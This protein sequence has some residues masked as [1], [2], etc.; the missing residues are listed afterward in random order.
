MQYAVACDTSSTL[1][2]AYPNGGIPHAYIVGKDGMICW[3]GHPMSGMKEALFKALQ[4]P[5]EA[6]APAP[7]NTKAKAAVNDMKAPAK[8]KEAI[9]VD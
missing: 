3:S 4:A 7:V 1:S 5:E 6:S 2:A 9:F 8:K